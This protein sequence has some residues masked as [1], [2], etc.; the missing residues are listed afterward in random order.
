MTDF[1]FQTKIRRFG[2]R[3]M[4]CRS[5]EIRSRQVFSGLWCAIFKTKGILKL[6]R[7]QYQQLLWASWCMA[8]D[9]CILQQRRILSVVFQDCDNQISK[10]RHTWPS[11][12]SSLPSGLDSWKE[13]WGTSHCHLSLLCHWFL[14]VF[15][16]SLFQ[17]DMHS[18]MFRVL[19]LLVAHSLN[20]TE[21]IKTRKTSIK[22][23]I[24]KP[25]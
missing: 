10:L 25:S 1:A 12:S 5:M 14:K 18:H 19:C 23:T 2:Y 9:T 7:N 24:S 11:S 16:C 22:S 15:I 21:A 4:R 20:Y 8:P 3:V 6:R 17:P 13:S